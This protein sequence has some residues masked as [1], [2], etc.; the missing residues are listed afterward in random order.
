[1]MLPGRGRLRRDRVGQHAL[2][3]FGAE[4]EEVEGLATYKSFFQYISE[5]SGNRSVGAQG[6][7]RGPVGAVPPQ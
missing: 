7:A 5:H 3:L 1:M 6:I 4:S 2:Y